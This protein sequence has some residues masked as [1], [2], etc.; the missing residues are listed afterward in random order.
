MIQVALTMLLAT[1]LAAA[2]S[3]EIICDST[4]VPVRIGKPGEAGRPGGNTYVL[5]HRTRCYHPPGR[6]G[7][8]EELKLACDLLI[9]AYGHEEGQSRCQDLLSRFD[10]DP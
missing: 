3:A 4:H 7:K 10:L 6:M 2:P 9:T 8:L 1:P 5:E